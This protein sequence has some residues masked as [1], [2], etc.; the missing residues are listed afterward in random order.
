MNLDPQR[1][2]PQKRF[3]VAGKRQTRLTRGGKTTLMADPQSLSSFDDANQVLK[4]TKKPL[5]VSLKR[6]QKSQRPG[7]K[8][9]TDQ[10][11]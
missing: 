6:F 4:K 7:V 9:G 1:N 10:N 5:Q 8:P 2:A 11:V 3:S